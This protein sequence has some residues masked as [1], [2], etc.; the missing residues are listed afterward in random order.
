MKPRSTLRMM[1]VSWGDVLWE[2]A[3]GKRW[4]L[5]GPTGRKAKRVG[6]TWRYCT[7][8]EWEEGR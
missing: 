1:V 5:Y 6:M 7:D 8:Q 3:D 2:D 4:W